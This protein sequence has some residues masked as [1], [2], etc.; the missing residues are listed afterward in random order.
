MPA[1]ARSIC[2]CSLPSSA[3]V[4]PSDPLPSLSGGCSRSWRGLVASVSCGD[5]GDG[6]DEPGIRG[7]GAGG[8]LRPP[9]LATGIVP[10]LCMLSS[11]APC[12][13]ERV[14]YVWSRWVA[15]MWR[16]TRSS[17]APIRLSSRACVAASACL[18]RRSRSL[19]SGVLCPDAARTRLLSSALAALVHVP[20]SRRKPSA[21]HALCTAEKTDSFRMEARLERISWS[22]LAVALSALTST[23]SLTVVLRSGPRRMRTSVSPFHPNPSSWSSSARSWRPVRSKMTSWR[24]CPD[25]EQTTVTPSAPGMSSSSRVFVCFGSGAVS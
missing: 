15:S 10:A 24:V 2:R 14:G 21:V 5:G 25:S 7:S 9:S 6:G 17:I 19:S 16:T 11:A 13:A 12:S 22:A 18:A 4:P 8:Q 1:S 20:P 23:R 3:P